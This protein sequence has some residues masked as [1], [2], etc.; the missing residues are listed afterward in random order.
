M[1]FRAEYQKDYLVDLMN[2]ILKKKR[3]D[4]LSS[5]QLKIDVNQMLRHVLSV[6][7]IFSFNPQDIS[8]LSVQTQTQQTY[9]MNQLDYDNFVRSMLD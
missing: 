7:L 3:E 8:I 2:L 5:L 9:Q 4:L 1:D 6:D